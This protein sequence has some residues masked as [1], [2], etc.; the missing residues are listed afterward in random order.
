MEKYIN[1][2][3]KPGKSPFYFLGALSCLFFGLLLLT[4]ACLLVFY[5]LDMDLA[6]DSIQGLTERQPYFGGL[7]RSLH[8]YAADGLMVT[9]L[10]H[11]LRV[12]LADQYRHARWL[13]WV[14]GVVLLGFVWI[15]GILGYWMVW[16]DRA[17]FIALA[18]SEFLNA[19]PL[20]GAELPRAF[21]TRESVTNL[22][23]FVIVALH[24]ALSILML[25]LLWLHL[26]RISRP[27]IFP[28]RG[29]A[30]IVILALLI[31]CILKPAT[32]G[33]RADPGQLAV[34]LPLDWFYL[35]IYPFLT[36]FPSSMSWT[37]LLGGT[38][39][40]IALPWIGSVPRKEPVTLALRRCNAC[41]NCYHDC[42]Y[43]AIA[44]RPRTD[45]RPYA[46]EA[47]VCSELCVSCGICV[48]SC[49]TAAL[50]LSDF[51]LVSIR[52]EVKKRLLE[53][54]M[55]KSGSRDVI[56]WCEKAL[57]A[58]T[59]KSQ[60]PWINPI[61]LPCIGT[62]HPIL[63]EDALKS[64]AGRIL[65]VSCPK[66]D[67]HYRIGNRLL[68]KRLQGQRKPYPKIQIDLS[69]VR[70]AYFSPVQV[71]EATGVLDRWVS[72]EVIGQK[73]RPMSGW[74]RGIT[75]GAVLAIPAILIFFFSGAPSY[76][77]YDENESLLILSLKYT[78]SPLHCREL[79]AEEL[80]RLPEHM[81]IPI[82]CTR[83][84]WP[85][86]VSLDIDG[87]KRLS[88]EYKPSGL[89][90]DGPSYIYE[91]F[92]LSPGS[93][94]IRLAVKELSGQPEAVRIER[95]D[96]QGGSAVVFPK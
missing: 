21:L 34:N 82:E 71:Q 27:V 88:R 59:I 5:R 56:F 18:T 2:C 42:P 93:H 11:G 38:L 77:F 68:E 41:T 10:L 57:P 62:I 46:Q 66:E 79:S 6:Y 45:R 85:I 1:L 53:G 32:S 7:I 22:F 61:M 16:D 19:I 81:R 96:F 31:L 3:F 76:S 91:K 39:L 87:E 74:I 58:E 26:I 20:F 54:R 24:I 23:F 86:L 94:E 73:S 13:A 35:W 55:G 33:P 12:F 84:R 29:L 4:G 63:I 89:W 69:K 70:F 30:A 17:H 72:G 50:T 52:G 78:A 47:V 40:L 15:E 51:S 36:A 44:M 48:G 92:K 43:E 8:R 60:R 37:L 65:L 95:I 90:Y 67:C 14:S 64:G 75:A 28:S 80:G 49:D 25:I 83:E 9:V